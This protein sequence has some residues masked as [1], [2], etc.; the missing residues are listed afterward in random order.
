[1]IISV[2][3]APLAFYK[4]KDSKKRKNEF[5]SFVLLKITIVMIMI[6]IR[7]TVHI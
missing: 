5:N 4:Q 3:I 6:I 2:K 1:L 7:L